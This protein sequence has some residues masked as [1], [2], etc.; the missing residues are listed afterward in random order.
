MLETQ[1]VNY[2]FGGKGYNYY[3]NTKPSDPSDSNPVDANTVKTLRNSLIGYYTYCKSLKTNPKDFIT[4][5]C[6]KANS[7]NDFSM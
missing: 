7:S 5:F 1:Y 3:K 4:K 6:T 2:I